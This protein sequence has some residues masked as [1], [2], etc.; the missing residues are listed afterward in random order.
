MTMEEICLQLD[1]NGI[2]E[3]LEHLPRELSELLDRKLRRVSVGTSA[4]Q[5]IKI[6]QFCGVTKRPLTVEELREVLSVKLG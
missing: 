3:A 5:A 1:D 2:L 6:L 4:R